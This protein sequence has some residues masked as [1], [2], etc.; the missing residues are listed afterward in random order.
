MSEEFDKIINGMS[1]LNEDQSGQLQGGFTQ[2][3]NNT[4]KDYIR[5][6]LDGTIGLADTSEVIH[7]TG[8]CSNVKDCSDSN[9]TKSCSNSTGVCEGSTNARGACLF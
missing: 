2:I 9:N 3:S 5:G 7:N 1:C 8:V 6:I 4:Y